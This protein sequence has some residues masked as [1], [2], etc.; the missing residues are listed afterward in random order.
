MLSS[1]SINNTELEDS[2]TEDLLN[3]TQ[4]ATHDIGKTYFK[5]LDKT[6]FCKICSV[7]IK[8][9]LLFNHIN[10]KEHRD[11]ED[12]FIMKCMTYCE[13]YNKEIKKR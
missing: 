11:I 1:D 12:Y 7:E 9:S 10:S 6:T 8:K 13:R 2:L 4:N 3:F 5:A